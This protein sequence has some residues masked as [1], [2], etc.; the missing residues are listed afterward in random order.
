MASALGGMSNLNVSSTAQPYHLSSGAGAGG[1]AAGGRG[2]LGSGNLGSGA[3]AGAGTGAGF[4]QYRGGTA[5]PP[6]YDPRASALPPMPQ[7]SLYGAGINT[8]AGGVHQQQQQ[9]VAAQQ[10][11]RPSFAF[12]NPPAPSGRPSV[13]DNP[14]HVGATG[15]GQWVG[16]GQGQAPVAGNQ[17]GG[18]AGAAAEDDDWEVLPATPDDAYAERP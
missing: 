4:L 10:A 18:G 16:Q 3:A 15:Q 5:A 1:L 7:V 17:Q 2:L 8:G 9:P 12:Y 6:A 11:G 13:G 14:F